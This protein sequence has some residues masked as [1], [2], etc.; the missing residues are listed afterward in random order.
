MYTYIPLLHSRRLLTCPLTPKAGKSLNARLEKL[1]NICT[2]VCVCVA[3]ESLNARLEKL[4]NKE[5]VMLFMKGEPAAAKCGFS[6]TIVNIL[7]EQG[8]TFGCVP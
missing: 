2:Y 6:R 4:V 1:V 8:V 7:N 3:G 5:P